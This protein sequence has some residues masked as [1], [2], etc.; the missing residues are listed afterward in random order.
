[1]AYFSEREAGAVPR[2]IEEITTTAWKGIWALI[3]KRLENGSFGASF[4]MQCGD[5]YGVIGHD[6]SMLEAAAAGDGIVWP[7]KLDQQPSTMEVLDLLEFS[8]QNV[9]QPVD[10]DYHS[11]YRHTHLS[12]NNEVGRAEF[13][14]DVERVLSRN[15]IAFEFGEN[16][17][18]RRIG[19]A[20]FSASFVN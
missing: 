4:P 3:R 6:E 10:G 19:P 1:M 5:G 15:G 2:T 14:A 17:E 13:C 16:G 18:A 12:F 8:Y 11:F 20:G 9:S 7:P